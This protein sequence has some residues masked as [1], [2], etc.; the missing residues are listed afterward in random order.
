MSLAWDIMATEGLQFFGKMTAS[1]SHE[2]KNTLA[3][4]NE[5][6][7]LLEDLSILAEKGRPLDLERV[8]RIAGQVANRSSG[9]TTC[10]RMNRF[11]HSTDDM[12]KGIG[13]GDTLDFVV[14]VSS[15]LA[16]MRGV[17]LESI[18]PAQEVTII[19]LPF[20]LENLL[21]PCLDYLTTGMGTG[22][23]VRLGSE[24]KG[25]RVEIRLTCSGRERVT[26][27]PSPP[28]VK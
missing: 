25:N 5:N 13:L 14:A 18:P 23:I 22:G 2:I 28:R 6:A 3:I 24:Q 9:P 20:F 8:K 19:T 15:R 21:W 1:I 26:F 11:A 17:Q 4:M 7:G 10:K 12:T 27:H 16:A